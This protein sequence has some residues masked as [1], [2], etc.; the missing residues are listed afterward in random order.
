M[1]PRR[2]SRRSRADECG[3][4]P[5]APRRDTA[6]PSHETVKGSGR[7]GGLGRGRANVPNGRQTTAGHL[8][9]SYP[10]GGSKLLS[11]NSQNLD[12]GIVD[13][14]LPVPGPAR[15]DAPHYRSS[16]LVPTWPA[17]EDSA[18]ATRS[19]TSLS[20]PDIQPLRTPTCCPRHGHVGE[21]EPESTAGL[22]RRFRRGGTR[23]RSSW[24]FDVI[25]FVLDA[26]RRTGT[27]PSRRAQGGVARRE[28]CRSSYP[29]RAPRPGL[30]HQ[31]RARPRRGSRLWA[32]G[33]ADDAGFRPSDHSRFLE[34]IAG[35]L[36]PVV[37]TG[38][39]SAA[40]LPQ[41]L[42]FHLSTRPKAA[43]IETPAS[44]A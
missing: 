16:S 29:V 30:C 31:R 12:M 42:V 11:Q 23:R 8:G 36:S 35:L 21:G 40:I 18:F 1:N 7:H 24:G 19:F 15:P 41:P 22:S 38:R 6:H 34:A 43:Q 33:R 39:F 10:L 37:A 27:A 20:T 4:R 25:S 3:V 32:R 9:Y 28:E 2:L 44:A 26:E 14:S 5:D 13:K 17:I